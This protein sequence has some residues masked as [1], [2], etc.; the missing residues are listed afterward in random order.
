M[1]TPVM[2]IHGM[3]CT[4]EVWSQFRSLFESRGV[5]VYTPTLR[6][7]MRV[8]MRARPPRGLRDLTLADYVTDLE[9]E[10]DEIEQETGMTPAVI[11]HSMGGLLASAL[12]ARGRASA[13]VFISP[14][15]PA[16]IRTFQS[17]LFWSSFSF[18]HRM[19][20]TPPVM[21][22]SQ[23]T[24]DR[25]VLN[26]LP[27]AE[28]AAVLEAMVHESGR[29]FADFAG[30][31]IDEA[32]VRVPVLVVAAGRDRLV[33]ASLV[34]LT[35]RKFAARGGEFR[36]YPNH[37]HWLYSEPGWETPANDIFAW[38]ATATAGAERAPMA[39]TSNE[40][41]PLAGE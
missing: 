35:G 36:E 16:G 21:R 33:P 37:G 28:R 3:C 22:P 26:M 39:A 11:G 8:G 5:K 9:K 6:P 27:A 1:N 25:M 13:G 32:A 10:V 31:P 38:L 15:A 19:G 23:R 24:L 17:H 7:E 34:R 2:M 41:Q 14:A 4:G 30:F 29:A 12:C 20:W 18:A 40:A